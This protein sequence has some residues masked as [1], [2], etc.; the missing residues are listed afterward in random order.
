MVAICRAMTSSGGGEARQLVSRMG[1]FYIA[2][3][4]VIL[5]V[6]LRFVN[7]TQL[8]A[9]VKESRDDLGNAIGRADLAG[10]L[11]EQR[12]SAAVP[13]HFVATLS[14][15]RCRRRVGARTFVTPRGNPS[16]RSKQCVQ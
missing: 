12:C 1:V 2:T 9:R 13:R 3:M 6:A 16:S 5:V 8:V 10:G 14:A 11:P 4:L 15:I 7:P